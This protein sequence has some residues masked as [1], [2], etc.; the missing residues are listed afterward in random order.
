MCLGFHAEE[1]IPF[2][3]PDIIV[4]APDRG[5]QRAILAVVHG[6]VRTVFVV[7][8]TG[9]P[10]PEPIRP[11]LTEKQRNRKAERLSREL[12]QLGFEVTLKP[13]TAQPSFIFVTELGIEN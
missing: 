5:S 7:L 10:Y 6:L 8:K 13:K 12:G 4:F 1:G 9:K 11:L 2:Q 3:K